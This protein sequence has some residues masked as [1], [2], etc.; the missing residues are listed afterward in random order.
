MRFNGINPSEISPKIFVSHEIINAIPPRSLRMATTSEQSYLAGVDILPREIH[1]YLNFAGKSH[2]H[3]NSLA[4]RVAA[5]FC[6]SELGEYE[7][8]HHPG[9]ALSVVL[10]S[11][12]EMEW[13]WGFGTIEYV[14]I[15]PRPYYH[16]TSETVIIGEDSINIEPQSSV[17][18]RPMIT[19]TMIAAANAL[20]ISV[21][22]S[23]VMRI[24]NPLGT[25]LQAGQVIKVDFSNRLVSIGSDVAMAYVDYTSSDWHPK[26]LGATT[27]EINDAGPTEVRWRDEW[28]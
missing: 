16:S 19:H 26:I 24:R 9:K 1:L 2:E 13:K 11:A 10:Q 15:A 3:A 18:V 28:M 7:P 4:R 12:S 22:G 21:G 17:P 8:T 25:Q 6:T 20:E 27:I 23:I 14:F 5:L